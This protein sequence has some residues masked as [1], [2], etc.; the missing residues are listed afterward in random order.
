[1]RLNKRTS[2]A[3]RE[4]TKKELL[5]KEI[6]LITRICG[7]HGIRGQLDAWRPR[8][9]SRSHKMDSL[10]RWSCWWQVEMSRCAGACELAKGN[11]SARKY[12]FVTV[13][14]PRGPWERNRDCNGVVRAVT[15]KFNYMKKAPTIEDRLSFCNY[16]RVCCWAVLY[17]ERQTYC[18][19]TEPVLTDNIPDLPP[20]QQ[21]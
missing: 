20:T 11:S 1:M 16:L 4:T 19:H 21:K 17:T 9:R 5:Q 10:S 15:S 12:K 2:Y 6:K 14:L 7:R 8:A 13:F 3:K 18:L